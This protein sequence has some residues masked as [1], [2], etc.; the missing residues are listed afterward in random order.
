MPHKN[1]KLVILNSN[2]LTLSG[3]KLRAKFIEQL[4]N[5]NIEFNLFGGNYWSK[6]RQYI[7]NAPNG[8]WPAFS[9]SKFTL[10]IE[11]EISPYYWSEKFADAILCYTI[12]IYYG[13]TNISDYFPKG[14]YY[15]IDINKS[16]TIKEI[17]DLINSDFFELNY[18]N[19]LNARK[20]IIE[21]FNLFSFINN[22]LNL[23]NDKC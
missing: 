13:C 18:H 19:L 4:C 20:L 11:N 9:N 3:H 1:T 7:D 16:N 14:S 6:F 21:K 22:E 2:I 23:H 10:I 5:S 17:N 12:P 15:T 8:K